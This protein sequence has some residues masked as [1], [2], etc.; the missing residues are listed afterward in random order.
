MLSCGLCGEL[1]AVASPGVELGEEDEV[2][3]CGA[4]TTSAFGSLFKKDIESEC[5][6]KL[7][8]KERNVQFIS[9][10]DRR[11]IRN[12]TLRCSLCVILIVASLEITRSNIN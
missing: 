7:N 10:T 3:A 2:C 4:G 1:L 12:F 11:P 6:V 9:L 5:S 8:F